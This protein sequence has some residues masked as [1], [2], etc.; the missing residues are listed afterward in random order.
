LKYDRSAR[1]VVASVDVV[2]QGLTAR[3]A[4]RAVRDAVELYIGEYEKIPGE[5]LDMTP[6]DIEDGCKDSGLGIDEVFRFKPKT[7]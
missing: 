3:E 6:D 1:V 4:L 7:N 5:L 2:S